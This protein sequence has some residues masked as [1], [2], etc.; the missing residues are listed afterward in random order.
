MKYNILW[1]ELT[2][3]QLSWLH[4]NV[5]GEYEISAMTR[6]LSLGF[7]IKSDRRLFQTTFKDKQG[8]DKIQM[9][10][11]LESVRQ[12]RCLREE[13]LNAVKE[14]IKHIENIQKGA[15]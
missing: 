10:R 12:N 15:I 11:D 8:L 13:D 6:F 14:Y 2:N 9:Q 3:N 4:D 1:Y 5:K 7:T